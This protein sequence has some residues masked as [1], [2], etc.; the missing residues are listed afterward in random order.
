VT[1]SIWLYLTPL[2]IL[3]GLLVIL[4]ILALL[5]RFAGGKYLRPIVTTLM[6]L[7]LV[8]RGMKKASEAAL[9]RQNP[10]LASA[11]KKLERYG[12]TKDPSRAQ[13]AMSNLTAAERRAYLDAAGDQVESLPQNRQMRRQMER[14]RKRGRR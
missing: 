11:I 10:D 9:E 4:G 6:K 13:A 1:A 8:G 7:P 12:A 2:W 3:V 14:A 5:G